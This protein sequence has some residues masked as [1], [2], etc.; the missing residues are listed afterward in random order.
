[1]ARRAAITPANRI[2]GR[3]RHIAADPDGPLSMVNPTTAAIL[4]SAGAQPA[5]NALSK[6]AQLSD[7]GQF[8]EQSAG[9][10]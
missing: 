2:I 8:E 5:L 3:E 10:H 6:T 7:P 1:M 9:F 4:D